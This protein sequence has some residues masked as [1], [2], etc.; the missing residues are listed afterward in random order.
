MPFSDCPTRCSAVA[1]GQ[2]RKAR[3]HRPRTANL[4]STRRGPSFRRSNA[5]LTRAASLLPAVRP[6][7]VGPLQVNSPTG[8][9]STACPRMSL[10]GFMRDWASSSRPICGETRRSPSGQQGAFSPGR[11][12]EDARECGRFFSWPA[13]SGVETIN[14]AHVQPASDYPR[15]SVHQ[16]R[17][18]D[19]EAARRI[20][21]ALR[22]FGVA[23]GNHHMYVAEIYALAGE[24]DRAFVQTLRHAP[25]C[26][27][28]RGDPCFE[29]RSMTRRTTRRLLTDLPL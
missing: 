26:F 4:T 22:A 12:R 8:R 1:E 27:T 17:A 9:K 6:M 14:V 7:G 25:A 3:L 5:A 16:L 29:A 15:S 13:P 23:A 28:L 11:R 24:S 18:Q 21:D 20:A 10:P 19:S 2:R